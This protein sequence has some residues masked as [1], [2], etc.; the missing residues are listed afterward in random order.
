MIS[1]VK[2]LRTDSIPLK[3]FS[4]SS[5]LVMAISTYPNGQLPCNDC[6]P[7]ERTHCLIHLLLMADT[8]LGIVLDGR[9]EQGVDEGG[10]SQAALAHHH[11]SEGS[12]SA[13]ALDE[14]RATAGTTHLLA[15]ILC[16]WFGRLAM[17]MALST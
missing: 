14:S 13:R 8:V 16:R 4:S 1:L 11:D 10:L 5:A 15:T 3:N 6:D 2:A 17:P 12:T 7:T 9:A